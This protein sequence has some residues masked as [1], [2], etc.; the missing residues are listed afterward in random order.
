MTTVE[1]EGDVLRPEPAVGEFLE[2][3]VYLV[4]DHVARA[5]LVAV[6]GDE[7][8]VVAVGLLAVLVWEAAPVARV[9]EDDGRAGV[10]RGLRDEEL[11]EGVED[12]CPG[13]RAVLEFED[14]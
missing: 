5:R 10:G 7:R 13:R 1:D 14:V 8:L 9:V 2:A 11:V 3:L 12:G 4:V 6:G